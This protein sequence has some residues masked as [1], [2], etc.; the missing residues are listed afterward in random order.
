[1]KVKDVM[2]AEV[3]YAEVPG[4]RAEALELLRKLSVSAVPVVKEGTEELLGMVTLRGLF[5]HSDEEQLGMLVDRDVQSVSPEDSIEDAAR[6]MVES[7]GRRLPVVKEKKLV[8]I[9]TVR[10]IV[11]RAVA[12]MGLEKPASDYMR[13]RLAVIWDGTPIRTAMEIMALAG[14]RALPVIDTEG[15]L[16]G[17]VDDADI[18][19]LS[20][21]ETEL[22]MGHMAGRSE[23]DSWTWDSE[24]RIYITKKK[25]KLPNKFVKDVMSKDLVTVTKRTSVSKC[26]EVMKQHKIEQTPVMSADGE[27]VGMIRDIDLLRAMI[28]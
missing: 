8:G 16:I 20:E 10:D 23:G 28:E 5:D 13:P 18:I 7:G 4:T 17:I 19:G 21:V 24:D 25:I 2:T 3:K 6:L 22:K 11:Y 12:G 15:K 9:V 1:M 27:L 26:A 14:L